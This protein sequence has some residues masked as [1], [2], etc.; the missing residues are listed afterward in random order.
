MGKLAFITEFVKIFL[1]FFPF[2]REWLAGHNSVSNKFVHRRA[3]L[4]GIDI[5]I[6]KLY[7]P[8]DNVCLIFWN[9]NLQFIYTNNN[10]N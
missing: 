1:D 6:F 7:M 4:G 10:L 8:D 3:L 9:T 2:I 5:P